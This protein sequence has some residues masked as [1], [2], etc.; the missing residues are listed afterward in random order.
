MI[1]QHL[2]FLD[3]HP[4]RF[5]PFNGTPYAHG[6]CTLKTQGW[7]KIK[8]AH[9]STWVLP[10]IYIKWNWW[11]LSCRTCPTMLWRPLNFQILRA[12]FVPHK[13][14]WHLWII[15]SEWALKCFTPTYLRGS[16]GRKHAQQTRLQATIQGL[17]PMPW[18][19]RSAT[20]RNY[21]SATI[22]WEKYG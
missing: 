16:T 20:R 8:A 21:S 17:L 2:M 3:M 11:P 14:D 1:C 15:K 18:K 12:R 7:G 10:T 22:I 6:S 13:V 4:A 19:T 9:G 5:V